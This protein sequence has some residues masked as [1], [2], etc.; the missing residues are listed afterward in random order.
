MKVA[1]KDVLYFETGP[2]NA[3]T[4]WV[5]PGEEFQ[6]ETQMN[7]GPWMDGHPE[8]EKLRELLVGGNPSSGCV[9]VQ[10]AE[11]GQ[12]L[13]V[14][15]GD[16]EVDNVGFT[17]F[18]GKTGAM[19]AWLGKGGIGEH[20][21][22]VEI[23]EGMIHWDDGVV[24]PVEPMLGFVGVSPG[25]TR[26]GNGWAGNWGGNF[27]IQEITTGAS[28]YLEVNVPGALLHIGD[29]HARQG[30]GEICGAGGIE[31]GG[32]AKITCHLIDKPSSM[33]GPRIENETHI[34]TVG[35]TRPAEDAFRKALEAMVL[36]LEDD[37][38]FTRGGAYLYLGQVLE[39]RC[40]QFVNPHFTYLAK[41]A[42]KYLEK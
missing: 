32:R 17:Y 29:M 33:V 42:R 3:P 16:I 4:L 14:D 28:V 35:M 37:Y 15:V 24:L 26:W 1:T 10:G 30:D 6:V 40:T 38:G 39:S 11:P 31:T 21:R 8:E 22:V 18:P 19:P 12:V 41:V 25:N 5:D 36:W 13:R 27:D 9:Y 2:D 7:P 34:M 20:H 23:R